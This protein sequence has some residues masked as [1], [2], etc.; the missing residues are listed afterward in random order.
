MIGELNSSAHAQVLPTVPPEW[1]ASNP[2]KPFEFYDEPSHA[3]A[4]RVSDD[5]CFVY[6]SN[7]GHDSIA[8]FELGTE[9][10]LTVVDYTPSGGRLPW[11]MSFAASGRFLLCQNQF[12]AAQGGEPRGLG[13]VVVFSVDAASG[14]LTPTGAVAE[15]TNT[16]A[17][18]ARL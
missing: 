8:I 7:R 11:C 16:M 9:R 6:A 14:R 17:V 10:K 12:S 18:Q 5:G 1:L 2:P 3:A 4:V 13:N 15:H